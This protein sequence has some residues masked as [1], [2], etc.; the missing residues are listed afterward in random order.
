MIN[1]FETFPHLLSPLK[2]GSVVFR[3]RMF[4]APIS[5]AEVVY[6]GQPGID[7]VMY[8]ERKAMGG[9]A[10]VI[11]GE[12]DVDPDEFKA[13][14]W[15][16]EIT[17][18]S[19]YNYPRLASAITRHGAVAVV[20]LCFAGVH[21]RFYDSGNGKPA[22]G[23]VDMTLPNGQKVAAMTDDRI[24]EVIAGFGKAALAAKEAGFD[25]VCLHGAHGFGLQQFMSPA[26]N[27]RTDRWGGNTENRCRFAVM[28]I[29]EIRKTCGWDYPVEIRISGSE[30][31]KDGYGIDEGCRIAEQLDGIA[32]VIHV[33][34]GALDRFNAESFSRTSL[35]MFYPQGR[36]VEYAAEIKKRVKK[37][38]VG[39][40]GG[41]SDPY[42]MED[43]LA[44]G[45]ADI[46]YMAREL[47]CDPDMPD[48]VRRGR[49]EDIR[50]C[51]RCLNCFAEG[52]AHGDILCA[53]NPEISRE[54]EAYYALPQPVKQRVLVIGGGIAGMQAALTASGYGHDVIL[55]E[56][57]GELGGRI[58]CERD[59]PFKKRLH[60]Y[61]LQQRALIAK[62]NIDLRLDAEVTPEYA[63]NERPDIVIAA[64]GSDPIT[65]DIPG[66]A[67]GNVY[68]AIEAFKK[69]DL[70]RGKTVV[71]GAGLAGTELAIYLKGEFGID[72]EIV[73]MLGDIS[74]GGN[75]THKMA[76]YDIIA[77]KNIPIH[78]NT[79]AVEITS[80]GVKCLG[81]EGE[82]SYNADTVICA[83]GMKPLQEEAMKFNRC[84]EVFHMIGDCRKAANILFANS[85]AHTA[86]KFIG[87][88]GR[89]E[90]ASG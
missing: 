5:S 14:R 26:M 7:A 40:V 51:M 43:I 1:A 72:V 88:Q 18:R 77:Q 32:D 50:K 20:E 45:K 27:T 63:E 68:Q 74:A 24:L 39:T 8:H 38:L 48:K 2:I 34:V 15:P 86:A 73:E 13:G 67:G 28:A 12:V 64:V 46:V 25:M 52:V 3:N 9:A 37:S 29:E 83:T 36:N 56:K 55:C 59:V 19:N 81:P 69:P 47:V 44:S 60:E 53:I 61:I 87:R 6:D 23:P 31:A 84:A 75:H 58:L 21:S 76:V 16:R 17:R 33:S 10:A 30:I 89:R 70:V 57:S 35:S 85:T 42:F 66:I 54:R 80:G 4:S 65:P 22:W 49:P 62:S 79:K 90:A 78:F 71:L 82:V 41:L 11:Y